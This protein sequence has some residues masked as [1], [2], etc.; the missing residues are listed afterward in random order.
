MKKII[1]II[2]LILV[3]G[4]IKA[5]FGL[6]EHL[7]VTNEPYNLTQTSF[8]SGGTV[9]LQDGDP[10]ITDKGLLWSSSGV[11]TISSY[12]GKKSFGSGPSSGTVT[13]THQVN[14]LNQSS[15]YFVRAYASNIVG[16]FYG[17]TYTVVTLPTLGEWGV[18][19]LITMMAAFGG[20]MVWRRI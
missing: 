2:A 12:L 18:I 8:T 13:F 5:D 6:F 16:T 11:P 4:I 17:E 15:T 10:S 19:A 7:I 3:S 14:G 9:T 20:W 1:L